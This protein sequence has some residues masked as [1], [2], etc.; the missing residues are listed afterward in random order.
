MHRDLKP[1]NVLL[2]ENG[3]IRICDFGTCRSDEE[4]VENTGSVGS[5]L[6]IAPEMWREEPYGPPIDVYSFAMTL[7]SIFRGPNITWEDGSLLAAGGHPTFQFINRVG[8]GT[9]YKKPEN[10]ERPIPEP[11]WELIQECWKHNPA[12]RPTFDDLVGRMRRGD[13]LTFPGTDMAAYREYQERIMKGNREATESMFSKFG[14]E[15]DANTIMRRARE[16]NALAVE[17]LKRSLLNKM[18]S[19]D[20]AQ[21]YRPYDFLKEIS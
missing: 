14:G 10:R 11:I 20:N 9:R 15:H 6:F 17:Q 3:E 5:P 12:D 19:D 21:E 13:E 7:Y 18:T 2:D 4:R 16:G 8:R 1:G